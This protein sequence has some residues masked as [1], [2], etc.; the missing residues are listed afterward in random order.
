MFCFKGLSTQVRAM[1]KISIG[2]EITISYIDLA[3]NKSE[4][5]ALLKKLYYLNCN[6][7]KCELNLDSTVNYSKF[8]NL[9]KQLMNDSITMH[10]ISAKH[11]WI[12]SNNTSTQLLSLYRE[13]Y[14]E[15]YPQ[16]TLILMLYLDV[17]IMV[18]NGSEESLNELC[19]EVDRNIKITH[20][21]NHQLYKQFL[22]FCNHFNISVK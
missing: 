18:T 9:F 22:R 5:Q 1:K 3:K 6:C 2:E 12:R 8:N 4:R 17:K 21:E 7:D 14:G 20:G 10:S 19:K 11:D 15:F 13:I 16:L